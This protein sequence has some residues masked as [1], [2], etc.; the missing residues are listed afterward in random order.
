MFKYLPK[1]PI[2]LPVLVP[3]SSSTRFLPDNA[4]NILCSNPADIFFAV[5]IP[6]SI[7]A[8]VNPNV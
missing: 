8:R 6:P 5:L 2:P 3:D 7:P 4:S 1:R